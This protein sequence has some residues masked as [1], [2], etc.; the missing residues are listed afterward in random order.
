M[1]EQKIRL[2][3]SECRYDSYTQEV[4]VRGWYDWEDENPSIDVWIDDRRL[5]S[6]ITGLP[7]LDVLEGNPELST[8]DLGYLLREKWESDA[9]PARCTVRF[10]AKGVTKQQTTSVKT[11]DRVV[12]SLREMENRYDFVHEAKPHLDVPAILKAFESLG[13]CVERTQFAASVFEDYV[14]TIDYEKNHPQYVREFP[15]GPLLNNKAMQHFLSFELMQMKP[16]SVY[17]DV[18]SSNSVTTDIVKQLYSPSRVWRQDLR[19]EKGVNGDL[20]GSDAASIPLPDESIDY[21]ALHC[22]LE[23]FENNSDV[24]FIREACRL[25]RPGGQ[26]CVIPLYIATTYIVLTS[27]S[28]WFHKYRRCDAPPE[29]DPR[30]RVSIVDS[31]Q[32]RQSKYF[33]PYVLY[34]DIIRPLQDRLDFTVY[35][36]ENFAEHQC[37]KF[38]LV[39]EKGSR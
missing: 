29:F 36:F 15:A 31:I 7:R 18:A 5:G 13:V 14:W 33:D 2:A 28:V 3:I 39:A 21:M 16:G 9:A 27:P 12:S 30:S 38:A 8:A 20:I 25:L 32:Q 19:Y 23:H 17:M 4:V 26:I 6:A 35:H 1:G 10:D 24:W 11:D 22:S 37:P 34:V